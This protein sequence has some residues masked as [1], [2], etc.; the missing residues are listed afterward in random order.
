M[1]PF[2]KKKN[3]KSIVVSQPQTRPTQ[4][5][6][7]SQLD[8][9]IPFATPETRLYDA[10]RE[11]VPVIDSALYKIERLI[12]G[13]RFRC[14]DKKI[15]KALNIFAATVRVG[16]SARG[17]EHFIYSYLDSLLMYGNAVGEIVLSSDKKSIVGLYNAALDDVVIKKDVNPFKIKICQRPPVGEPV[18]VKDPQLIMFTALN[19]NPGEVTGQ[20]VLHSLPFV[21]SILLKVYQSIGLNFDRVGNL[22]FAVTYKPSGD[23]IDH[24]YA[25]ERAEQIA[26]EWSEGMKA[27]RYGDIRDFVAVGDVDIKVIG[28]DNQIL[29]CEVPVRQMLEQIVAKLSLPPFMLGLSWSTTERMS[30]QQADA[31]NGEIAYYRRLLDPVIDKI[32]N[33]FLALNGMRTDYQIQWDIL[34]FDDQLDAARIRLYNAQAEQIELSNNTEP[35]P[36]PVD[37]SVE[38]ETSEITI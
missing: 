34:S 16:G 25:K 35:E 27:A 13:F 8:N 14:E 19:P 2:K 28:A 12:G 31:L 26:K 29:D 4:S 15:E 20:S 38:N 37:I 5:Q 23:G 30:Q 36:I 11:A 9:Y 24:A 3:R 21:T 10:M 32:C 22:R 33:A 18:P 6:P 1:L 7:F 17:I